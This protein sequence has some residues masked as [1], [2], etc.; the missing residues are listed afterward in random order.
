MTHSE[1]FIPPRVLRNT[2]VQ[3]V[4]ASSRIRAWGQN[5]MV[6][7]G[8][9]IIFETGNGARLQGI[10]SPQV[11]AASKAV[12]VLL[13]GW[14]GSSHSTYILC[15]GRVLYRHGY[16]IFRL[17]FRDHG[18]THHLNE[19]LFYATLLDEVFES[20]VQATQLEP[21]VPVFLIGFSMGANFAL[22]I[23]RRCSTEPIDH[24]LHVA[25]ISPGLNPTTSTDAIDNDWL[26]KRYFL[27]KWRRSLK[28][29]QELYPELYD[30]S[31]MWPLTTVREMTDWMIERYSDF[32]C[33]EEYFK[34]Y[35]LTANALKAVGV[36]TTMIISE[37]DPI[38]GIEDFHGLELNSMTEMIIHRYGGHNGFIS[39]IPF[40][41]WY[42]E[43]LLDLYERKLQRSL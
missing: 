16:S 19:G 32:S 34:R 3:T 39:R 40:S 11:G 33:T 27:K 9:E 28:R 24:L 29:K 21:G 13:H 23:A 35:E 17:N 43:K 2:Y 7:S 30:F 37:D 6:D 15:T 1:L 14:E 25:A 20:V 41:C 18:E 12:V 38:I 42:E 36:P 26:L 4:L 5:P 8:R 22:R 10:Y 31:E